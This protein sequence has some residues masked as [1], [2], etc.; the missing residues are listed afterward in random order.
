M[1]KL[2]VLIFLILSSC[3]KNSNTGSTTPTQPGTIQSSSVISDKSSLFLGLNDFNS[4]R[5]GTILITNNSSSET[6]TLATTYIGDGQFQILSNTCNNS[7]LASNQTCQF[8]I[9]FL[10]SGSTAKAYKGIISVINGSKRLDIPLY[11]YS[12]NFNELDFLIEKIIE[13]Q[14]Q[15]TNQSTNKYLGAWQTDTNVSYL[16][17]QAVIIDALISG[18]NFYLGNTNSSNFT[19]LQTSNINF[20]TEPVSNWKVLDK[21]LNFLFINDKNTLSNVS[22]DSFLLLDNSATND[23]ELS[24][25]KWSQSKTSKVKNLSPALIDTINSNYKKIYNSDITSYSLISNQFKDSFKIISTDT[26]NQI[27]GQT[28]SIIAH[29]VESMNLNTKTSDYFFEN[30]LKSTSLLFD[31]LKNQNKSSDLADLSKFMINHWYYDFDDIQD[32]TNAFATYQN[33]KYNSSAF[34]FTTYTKPSFNLT[35]L[36]SD[37]LWW[38]L[39]YNAYFTN[40]YSCRNISY[41]FLN[42][43]QAYLS[44]QLTDN[45]KLKTYIYLQDG[46]LEIKNYSGCLYDDS[47]KTFQSHINVNNTYN[48]NNGLGVLLRAYHKVPD[49]VVSVDSR[50][51]L[52]KQILTELSPGGSLDLDSS[53]TNPLYLSEVLKAFS[54]LAK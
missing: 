36:A 34:N 51:N 27:S 53:S 19:T 40:N 7:K 23:L 35:T 15:S 20:L 49:G 6:Y 14:V 29:I 21:S 28:S 42:L 41:A 33:L 47:S 50:I 12:Y 22:D 25:T 9:R 38:I 24:L 43:A 13:K 11:A 37:K 26:S 4:S 45:E 16:E 52:Y 31:S 30:S 3:V 46:L 18:S 1:K 54:E 5:N 10:D 39:D 17:S 2:T 32:P 44:G 8:S 48:A